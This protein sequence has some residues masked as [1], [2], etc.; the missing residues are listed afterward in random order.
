MPVL[1]P[2]VVL[3]TEPRTMPSGFHGSDVTVAPGSQR[4]AQETRSHPQLEERVSVEGKEEVVAVKNCTGPW[5][6][7]PSCKIKMEVRGTI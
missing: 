1:S 3:F 2:A 6:G 5:T 7:Y 4:S